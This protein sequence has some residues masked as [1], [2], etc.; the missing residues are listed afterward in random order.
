MSRNI[1]V[2]QQGH[3]Y[4][5]YNRGANRNPIFFEDDN[6][7]FLLRRIKKYTRRY[8]ISVIAYCLMPNH[9]HFLLQQLDKNTVGQCIQY[10]F[11]S[12]TKAINEKY[13]RSGTLFEGPYRAIHVDNEPYLIHLCSYIHRNPK[14]ARLVDQLENWL[15]SNYLE[16]IGKRKGKLYDKSFVQDHFHSAEK[17]QEFVLYRI[18]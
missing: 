12:Y 13:G 18:Y 6:Y 5:V 14:E 3:F 15:W 8:A 17:Y 9:Y 2:Y 4:H 11:N 16:W 7:L 1:P 10:T